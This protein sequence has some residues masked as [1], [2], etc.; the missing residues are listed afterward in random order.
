M[1][2]WIPAKLFMS[3]SARDS[4]SLRRFVS[5]VTEREKRFENFTIEDCHHQT[6]VWR[7]EVQALGPDRL[8]ALDAHLKLI[9]ADAF[10]LV[11]QASRLLAARDSQ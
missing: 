11:R 3:K 5:D 10:A 9:A 2:N 8:N 1:L 7:S 6:S 4:R